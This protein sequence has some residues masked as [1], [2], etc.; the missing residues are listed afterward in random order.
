MDKQTQDE[1][2]NFPLTESK[3]LPESLNLSELYLESG[4]YCICLV[5]LHLTVICG[6]SKA[7]D[8]MC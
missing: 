3:T 7:S 5:C 2:L 1:A 6:V 8:M 4:T